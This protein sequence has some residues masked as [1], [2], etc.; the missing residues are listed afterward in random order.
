MDLETDQIVDLISIF[1][2][3]MRQNNASSIVDFDV[4][5]WSSD[6]DNHDAIYVIRD[7]FSH[8]LKEMK[9]IHPVTIRYVGAPKYQFSLTDI[10]INSIDSIY[11]RIKTM[12]IDY[13]KSREVIGFDIRIDNES[14]VI[15]HGNIS[16]T[17]PSEINTL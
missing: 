15:D 8:V 6:K 5:I 9:N 1:K 7:L 13:L 12:M 14:K 10:D 17:F 2:S 16:I 11:E 4:A 3:R